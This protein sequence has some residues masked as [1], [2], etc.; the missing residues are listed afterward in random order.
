MNLDS[1]LEPVFEIFATILSFIYSIVPNYGVAIILFTIFMM[2]LITPLTVKSTKSML[3]MQRLQPELKALQNKYKGD[4]E[5]LNVELMAFYKENDI[6]PLG[7]CLPLLAQSPVFIVMYRLLSGLTYREGGV[8]A[9]VGNVIGAQ[10][11]G[12]VPTAWVYDE[13][14]FNPQHLSESSRLFRD[15]RETTKMNFLGMDLSISPKTA[16]AVGIGTFLPF[17]GLLVATLVIQIYQNRQIQSRN[18]GAQQ[19]AQQQIILKVMPF[20]L[21]IFAFNLPAAMALYWGVQGLCRVATQGYITKR[22]Y[23]DEHGQPIAHTK[24]DAD[25]GS[26][27]PG[28]PS[29]SK[30]GSAPT[31]GNQKALANKGDQRSPAKNKSGSAGQATKSKAKAGG[32]NAQRKGRKSTT[33]AGN[34][35]SSKPS[36]GGRASGAPRPGGTRG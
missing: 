17:L 15:L 4:R 18:T 29:T 2:A 21:P 33:T 32:G 12:K 14:R 31:K 3:Q 7:G 1:I 13:Q 35:R 30:S 8:G 5:Q 9:G 28:K 19:N 23:R 36:G 11:A 20:F 22:F 10:H 34:G 24:K 25:D 6:S 27:K 26:Q 16:L